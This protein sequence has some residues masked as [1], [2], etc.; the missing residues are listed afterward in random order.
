MYARD[1]A[2]NYDATLH[3]L[4]VAENISARFGLD[5]DPAISPDMQRDV[6][7]D[8]RTRLVGLMSDIAGVKMQ[9]VVRTSNATA[10][11]IVD[12]AN[13]AN[14]D[15]IVMG[16]H[17]RT[18]IPHFF[19]GSVAERVVRTASRPV[20]TVRHREREFVVPDQPAEATRA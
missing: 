5:M 14:I 19:I 10:Q 2:R 3:V 1:L 6:E 4:H 13:E 18:G 17:G 20:L 8:A 7:E 12:Y 11:T 9:A 16:T 15:L